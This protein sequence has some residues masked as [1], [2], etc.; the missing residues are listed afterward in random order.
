MGWRAMSDH[1]RTVLFCLLYSLCLID[2]L[3]V[4]RLGAC[5][6]DETT[7]IIVLFPRLV[8]VLIV[9][10]GWRAFSTSMDGLVVV[11]CGPVAVGTHVGGAFPM[12]IFHVSSCK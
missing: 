8:L 6:H 7:S 12:F 5:V 11:D 10:S 9:A 3:L 1:S 4:L 2:V